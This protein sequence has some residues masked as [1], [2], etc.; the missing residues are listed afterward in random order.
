MNLKEI[1][2][3]KEKINKIEKE[4]KILKKEKDDR[5]VV[6]SVI[7][8]FCYLGLLG[9]IGLMTKMFFSSHFDLY[10]IFLII[11]LI[12]GL[13]IYGIF[14]EFVIFIY[15][16][17][18]YK[19]KDKYHRLSYEYFRSYNKKE[20]DFIKENYKILNNKKLSYN[21]HSF[22]ETLILSK[23]ENMNNN[24][25]IEKEGIIKNIIKE[26]NETDIKEKIIKIIENK[27]KHSEIDQEEKI[28]KIFNTK[29]VLKSI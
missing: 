17:K 20:V 10:S 4:M 29:K 5:E 15:R 12:P 11:A 13:L 18:K 14:S 1:R 27:L 26:I 2:D 22:Y 19:A 25:L 6:E 9:L 24:E 7:N 28:N 21:Y 3:N 8:M 23:I 16:N